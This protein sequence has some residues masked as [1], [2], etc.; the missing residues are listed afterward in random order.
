M[1][2]MGWR[3]ICS[4]DVSTKFVS[5]RHGQRHGQWPGGPQYPIDVHSWYLAHT[6][7]VAQQPNMPGPSSAA[8]FDMALASPPGT[9]PPPSYKEAMSEKP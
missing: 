1:A 8:G 5:R 4:A 7:H 3:V 2:S 9:V 6:G